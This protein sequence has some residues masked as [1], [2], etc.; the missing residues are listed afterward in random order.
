MADPKV[1]ARAH[2]KAAPMVQ[3]RCGM[4]FMAAKVG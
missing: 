4:V 3:M 1:R 2:V